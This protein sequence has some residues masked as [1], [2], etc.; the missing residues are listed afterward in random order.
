MALTIAE[1]EVEVTV[2]GSKVPAKVG[3]DIESDLSAFHRVDDWRALDGP[4]FFRYAVRL[5]AYSGVM[6]ARVYERQREESP[7]GAAAQGAAP[8]SAG[9]SSDPNLINKLAADGWLEH[10][11][12]QG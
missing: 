2:D 12:E 7:G 3:D 9:A 11:T 8:R 5:S 6:A 1:A 10:R 4:R